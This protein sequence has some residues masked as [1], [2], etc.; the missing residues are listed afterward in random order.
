MSTLVCPLVGDSPHISQAQRDILATW[1]CV[2]V[3]ISPYKDSRNRTA[4]QNNYLWSAVYPEIA[5]YCGY[6]TEEVHEWC[7][8]AFLPRSFVTINGIEREVAKST[9]TLTTGEFT[10][11]IESIRAWAGSQLGISIPE[12]HYTIAQ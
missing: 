12:P 10:Q 2:E 11:Y 8:L 9:T 5:N 1:R 4:S 3:K 6:S 7:K